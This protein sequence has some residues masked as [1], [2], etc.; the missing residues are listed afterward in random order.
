MRYLFLIS[1]LLISACEKIAAYSVAHFTNTD[2]IEIDRSLYPCAE[3]EYLRAGVCTSCPDG[4]TNPAGDD[5]LK[6]SDTE[7]TP[8]ICSENEYVYEHQCISCP[9]GKT[10]DAGDV[11]TGYNTSCE[12]EWLVT[13]GSDQHLG[14]MA[15]ALERGDDRLLVTSYRGANTVGYVLAKKDGDK[16]YYGFPSKSEF[17]TPNAFPHGLSWRNSLHGV[18]EFKG[19]TY[20]TGLGTISSNDDSIDSFVTKITDYE[21]IKSPNDVIATGIQEDSDEN[22]YIVG[23]GTLEV[24]VGDEKYTLDASLDA[25]IFKINFNLVIKDDLKWFKIFGSSG[26]DSFNAIAIDRENNLIAVGYFSASIDDGANSLNHVGK[27]DILVAKYSS[28]GDLLWVRGVGS[29]GDDEALAVTVDEDKN[30]YITGYT[31]SSRGS[32]DLSATSNETYKKNVL[33]LKFDAKGNL[34]RTLVWGSNSDDQGKGIV[35]D[36]T[37]KMPVIVGDFSETIEIK[38][39][40][41]FS[42]KGGQDIFIARFANDSPNPDAFRRAGGIEDD[43]GNAIAIEGQNIYIT[44]SFQNEADFASKIANST[45]GEDLFVWRF[46]F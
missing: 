41:R 42:S 36:G 24:E 39:G 40:D 16:G 9:E 44:G 6:V 33:L 3:N 7:C 30:I 45:K 34:Q 46:S 26:A 5:P 35:W 12:V 27:K 10:R 15:I 21:H 18:F 23:N 28:G 11:A 29:T 31:Y 14:G 25:F 43:F 20:P 22:C 13:K 19:V 37:V 38:N 4:S 1:L 2:G 32:K 17:E 8:T